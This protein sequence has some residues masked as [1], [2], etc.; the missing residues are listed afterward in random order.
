LNEE[1]GTIS[2]SQLTAQSQPMLLK[3]EKKYPIR[4]HCITEDLKNIL[5]Y[6]RST[7]RSGHNFRSGK[8]II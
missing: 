1:E 6:N 3:I 8:K 4:Y 2:R 7:I 5:A